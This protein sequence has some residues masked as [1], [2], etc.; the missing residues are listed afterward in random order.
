MVGEISAFNST[1]QSER[2]YRE[3]GGEAV[4]RQ[5]NEREVSQQ[6]GPVDSIAFSPEAIA[7]AQNV[8][9]T[10]EGS[11]TQATAEQEAPPPQPEQQREAGSIDIRV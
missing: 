7:L 6:E 11:E 4:T 3:N 1:I 8:P 2:T 9:P 5:D 10:G